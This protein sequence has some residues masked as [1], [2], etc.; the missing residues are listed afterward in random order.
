M[1]LSQDRTSELWRNFRPRIEEI[2]GRKGTDRF[3]VHVFEAGRSYANVEPAA[4]FEKWAAVEAGT[5]ALVPNGME[6]LHLPGGKY[7]VFIHI[8]TPQMFAKTFQFIF[9]EWMPASG[10]EIDNRPQFEV[11]GESYDPFDPDSQEEIWVPIKV[12]R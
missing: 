12:K 4:V 8:G 9:R 10:Y 5:E 1:S 2:T 3:S 7:A 11:L 6:S